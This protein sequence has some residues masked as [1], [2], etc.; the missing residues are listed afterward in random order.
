[1]PI[2]KHH[3]IRHFRE[4]FHWSSDEQGAGADIIIAA[5]GMAVPVLLGLLCGHEAAGFAAALGSFAINRTEIGAAIGIRDSIGRQIESLGI[6]GLATIIA[7]TLAGHGGFSLVTLVVVAVSAAVIGGF[8]R[9]L[10][11][12]TTRFIVF[13]MLVSA[14]PHL[15]WQGGADPLLMIVLGA[16]WTAGLGLGWAW[17]ISPRG[18]PPQGTIT[19]PPLL[20]TSQRLTHFR[21]SLRRL[22]GWS[23]PLRLGACLAVSTVLQWVWPHHHLHWIS[24]T[25]VLLLSRRPESGAVKTTQRTL[26][27]GI[28]VLLAGFLLRAPLPASALVIMIGVLA[29]A[30]SHLKQRNYLAYAVVMTPLVVLIID[31]GQ[32]AG[33]ALLTD[34]LVATVIGGLLV[35]CADLTLSPRA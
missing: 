4:V 20:S 18:Q 15:S 6:I 25:I 30:R 35:T 32:P 17:F 5:L 10:A 28:G 26:G 24:L 29:G 27:T 7:M 12:T 33:W 9:K 22:T 14:A 8:S 21:R 23:Y 34:R 13:L 2:I 16:L 3:A 1:M 19:P 11:I 31:A